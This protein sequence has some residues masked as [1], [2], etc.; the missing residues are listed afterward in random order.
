MRSLYYLAFGMAFVGAQACSS[1]AP[2]PAPTFHESDSTQASTDDV[3]E[4][5]PPPDEAPD[6]LA[7]GEGTPLDPVDCSVTFT[8]DVFPRIKDQWRCGASA[9]HG[10][11]GAHNPVMDT[12]SEDATYLVLT[13]FVHSGKRL[14]DTK[15]TSAD[16]SALTC[17]MSGTCGQRMPY[18]GVSDLDL[19]VVKS[20]LE[21]G[22]RR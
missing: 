17:L 5:T 4:E 2:P 21:C 15:S 19:S 7:P 14:V 8:K 9:C 1:E 13:T 11:P 16:A 6:E 22:A 3:G 20:W 12:K 18:Q 10:Q